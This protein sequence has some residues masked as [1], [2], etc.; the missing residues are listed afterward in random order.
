MGLDKNIQI[1]IRDN[2]KN[3]KN[4]LNETLYLSILKLSAQHGKRVTTESITRLYLNF[5]HDILKEV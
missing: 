3:R 4:I 2:G 1:E 5:L